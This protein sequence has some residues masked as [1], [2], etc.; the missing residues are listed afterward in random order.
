MA[1]SLFEV[2]IRRLH[3]RRPADELERAAIREAIL[4]LE[5]IEYRVK[6][7]RRFDRD[8][9]EAGNPENS[10]G[11]KDSLPGIRE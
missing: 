3:H 4:M 1:E 10:E 5:G 7:A 8:L 11:T 2:E 9:S 6:A